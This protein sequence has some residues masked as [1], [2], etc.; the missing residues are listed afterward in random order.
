MGCLVW[1]LDGEKM[2]LSRRVCLGVRVCE[3]LKKKGK[4]KLGKQWADSLLVRK[5]GQN[6]ASSIEIVFFFQFFQTIRPKVGRIVGRIC[7]NATF[8]SFF[9]LFFKTLHIRPDMRQWPKI[10]L[11]CPP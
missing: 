2:D 5:S 6:P 9:F 3:V 8:F 11:F 4:K 10:F 1:R 7:Y